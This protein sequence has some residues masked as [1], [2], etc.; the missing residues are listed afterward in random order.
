M[1]KKQLNFT[2]L[3]L[4]LANIMSGLDG[5]I[6]NTAIPAIVSALHGIKFMGWIVA[7]FLLGMSISIPLWTKIGEKLTNKTA[8]MVAVSLFVIGSFLQG[9]APNIYFFLASRLLMGLGAGGMGSLPYIIVG[10]IIPNIKQ[11]T[12]ILGLLTACFNGAAILGPLIGGSL[13]DLLSWHWVFFINVPIGLITI[14]ICAVYYRPQMPKSQ[15]KL[16]VKGG[17]SLVLG[18]LSFMLGIQLWGI[19]ANWIVLVLVAIS[20]VLLYGF[21]RAEKTATSPIVPLEIFQNRALDGDFLLFAFSWGAFIAVNTYLPTWSQALLGMSALLGGMALI[22]NSL[23]EIIASQSVAG[24]QEKLSTFWIVFLG[25]VAMLISSL[26]MFLAG[27]D[28]PL[29]W[30]VIICTFSGVGVGFIFVSLQ[31]KVQLDANLE[32]MATA[33]STSYLIRILAQTVMSAVYGVIMNLALENGVRGQ[34]HI[35]MSMMNKLSDAKTAKA[36]PEALLPQMRAIFHQGIHEIMLVS[37]VLIVCAFGLNFYY[38]FRQRHQ[39]H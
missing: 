33:T 32:N 21:F 19:A 25:L 23:I 11:R 20:I 29:M 5:T 28:T 36:L 31:V 24:L 6:V 34:K 38:N 1:T 13:V 27:V 17:V 26:G 14:A 3:A 22:P 30:L 35:T 4:M 18:L 16:D 15:A 12:Q 8:M 39:V 2:I 37:C 7:V 10:Y 9:I